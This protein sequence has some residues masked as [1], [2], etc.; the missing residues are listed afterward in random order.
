MSAGHLGDDL[1]RAHVQS[2]EQAGGAVA[3]IVMGAPGW[4][5]GQDRQGRG[6]AVQR[7]D[8]GLLIHAQHQRPLRRIQYSP[9]MS[10]TFSMNCG[11]ADSFQVCSRWGL[12]PNA[13]QIREMV[14][15]LIPVAR[16]IDRV[17]Q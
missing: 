9:T 2:G 1:T 3:D 14:V 8:L 15:W 13:R 12:S 11:S 17:D 7:L 5:G 6:R 4:G 10:R 16:A